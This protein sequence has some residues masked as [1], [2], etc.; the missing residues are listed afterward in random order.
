MINLPDM[1][2]IKLVDINSITDVGYKNVV[3][4]TVDDDSTFTFANGLISH[5]SAAA[6]ISAVRIPD[7]HG[8][9]PLRGKVMNVR[10]ENPKDVIANQI[11]GD[12]M[13]AV[14]LIIGQ[15]ANRPDLRYGQ[16]W[17]AADQ[18]PDGANITALL[19]NFFHLN[20][21]ELFDNNQP[22]FFYAFQTPF[23]IQ[24]K[25]KNRHYWYAHNYHEYDPKDWKNCPKPTRAKGLGSL[26]E[27]DWIYSLQNPQLIALTDDGTL[28][29]V[30]DL[31]FNVDRADD[32]KTW[33]ALN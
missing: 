15:K 2:S 31:I 1:A 20:W 23:I 25:G 22:P 11:I 10:G 24:E 13:T 21:P 27:A 18:D 6:M 32:R 3:D 9:L 12:I 4:L 33:V 16:V 29:G 28:G 7:I 30:L 19:V 8:A 14:G 17:L 26:E 5:N